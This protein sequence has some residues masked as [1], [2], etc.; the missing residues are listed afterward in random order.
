MDIYCDGDAMNVLLLKTT[1]NAILYTDS[2][3]NIATNFSTIQ[4]S[5][6]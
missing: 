2:Y 1:T 5:I 4:L 6:V 3:V